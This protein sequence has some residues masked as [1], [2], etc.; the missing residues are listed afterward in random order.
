[1]ETINERVQKVLKASSLT[2]SEFAEK[3]G[4]KQGSLSLI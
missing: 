1:M 3:I 2:Q 4:I